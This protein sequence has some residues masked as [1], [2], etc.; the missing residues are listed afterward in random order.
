MFPFAVN[1]DIHKE[2]V[3]SVFMPDYPILKN[4]TLTYL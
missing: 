1:V 2:S 3:P 4:I